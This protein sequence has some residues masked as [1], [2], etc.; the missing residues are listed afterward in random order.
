MTRFRRRIQAFSERLGYSIIPD[1]RLGKFDHARHLREL[2]TLAG[3]NCVVDVGANIGQFREFLRHHVDYRGRIVSF[4]PIAELHAVIAGLARTDPLWET[5]Q[6]ALGE[7]DG[8]VAI[9]VTAER[10]LSSFL[11]ADNRSLQSMG[12]A[13]YLRDTAVV[14]REAVPMRR[15]DGVLDSVVE[16]DARIFLKTDTQGYDVNVVRGAAGCLDRIAVMQIELSVRDVY[17][18]APRYLEGLQEMDERGFAITGMYPVQR[19]PQFRVVNF[20]CVLVNSALVEAF[21]R[22]EARPPMP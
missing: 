21:T 14:R 6:L 13:K 17:V 20:D 22:P 12:Y 15:L 5:H 8:E 18:G 19:D 3:V 1:W 4:E 10:T 16:P 9:N 2:F 7:T 11:P